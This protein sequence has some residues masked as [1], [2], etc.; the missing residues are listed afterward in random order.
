[1]TSKNEIGEV[2][3][4]TREKV[5]SLGSSKADPRI[6]SNGK[7]YAAISTRSPDF[8]LTL[9]TEGAKSGLSTGLIHGANGI[10]EHAAFIELTAPI[11]QLDIG[12]IYH[13]SKHLDFLSHQVDCL[14]RSLA[15]VQAGQQ[16][17][18]TQL[19]TSLLA[20]LKQAGCDFKFALRNLD[21]IV[22]EQLHAA[23]MP[24][25]ISGIHDAEKALHEKT[26][27]WEYR[28]KTADLY[29]WSKMPGELEKSVYFKS[30]FITAIGHAAQALLKNGNEH[31]LRLSRLKLRELA[32]PLIGILEE[33]KDKKEW[34]HGALAKDYDPR[35]S[36]GMFDWNTDAPDVA[37]EKLMAHADRM[38]EAVEYLVNLSFV[39]CLNPCR[40]IMV[41]EVSNNF[42]K[43]GVAPPLPVPDAIK[44][45]LLNRS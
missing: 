39:D 31:V 29:L 42:E 25:V 23:Y 44:G 18:L 33:C 24:S 3:A 14:N 38:I 16:E 45:L 19:H 2:E 20:S 43:L 6:Y 41:L 35:A 11:G 36:F 21:T 1:M 37:V 17:I 5:L 13:I 28:L 7:V 30:L 9:H 10:A 12:A 22:E 26:L 34:I 4:R 8:E 40:A 32:A 15:M 27:H